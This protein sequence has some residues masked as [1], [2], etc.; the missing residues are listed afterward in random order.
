M[1][2]RFGQDF[3]QVRVHD[4]GG[5]ARSARTADA[6]AFTMG[7]DI[8]FGA[9]RYR[10]GTLA[11]NALIGHELAHTIQQK[12][13]RNGNAAEER[14]LERAAEHA[15]IGAALGTPVR[16]APVSQAP[17]IQLR[18]VTPGGF[19]EEVEEFMTLFHVPDRAV[20]VMQGMKKTFM[21]MAA[22]L[23][24][25]YV[26]WRGTYISLSGTSRTF[27]HKHKD[28]EKLD[29]LE[30]GPDG[31]IRNGPAW[32]KGKRKL[33]IHF[34]PG[35]FRPAVGPMTATDADEIDVGDAATV[36]SFVQ[37]L[38]HEATH[39]LRFVTGA[40]PNPKDVADAVRIGVADEAAA[41]TSEGAAVGDMPK[42]VRAT[43]EPVGSLQDRDIQR[44]VSPAFNL[45][46][47][48]LFFFGFELNQ[49]KKAENLTLEETND[50]ESQVEK[51]KPIIT[52]RPRTM[53]DVFSPTRY[54][55][56][57]SA[58]KACERDWIQFQKKHQPG[59]P[60]FDQLREP[61]L[62]KH[63]RD[64]LEGKVAYLP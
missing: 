40:N 27:P 63:A 46:Y 24:R 56:L 60:D 29:E 32:A 23:D 44:D 8:Y 50:I 55:D 10:P 13:A 19:G 12:N 52:R 22:E 61:I 33:V 59:D 54:G 11:G 2:S 18:Q 49:A 17:A 41:R 28:L 25:H 15:G 43:A 51:G 1:E 45:T 57:F 35:S 5:A 16:V 26:S 31:V 21:P 20:D 9:H 38:A 14:G 53:N 34:G 7:Q 36:A 39:A 48:E 4:D 58:R 42:S 30:L 3:S 6:D 62:Q 47:L 64:F 37:T